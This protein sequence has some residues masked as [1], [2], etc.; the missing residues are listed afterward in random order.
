MEEVVEAVCGRDAWTKKLANRP[1]RVCQLVHSSAEVKR[2]YFMLLRNSTSMICTSMT[3]IPA[4]SA[5]VLF[6]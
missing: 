1:R 2:L 3:E 5:Q 6:V 4:T